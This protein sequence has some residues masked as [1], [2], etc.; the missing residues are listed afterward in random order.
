[1]PVAAWFSS[2]DTCALAASSACFSGP[3]VT[4]SWSVRACVTLVEFTSRTMS[5]WNTCSTSG[6]AT[7]MPISAAMITRA[8]PGPSRRKMFF[9]E[10]IVEVRKRSRLKMMRPHTIA[11]GTASHRL[12]RT[13]VS[14][15]NII[16]SD[17]T[18]AVPA[19]TRNICTKRGTS[20]GTSS[21]TSLSAPPSTAIRRTATDAVVED[22]DGAGGAGAARMPRPRMPRARAPRRGSPR[23]RR[24]AGALGAVDHHGVVV[25]GG[26]VV[27][28]GLDRLG[29][30]R[31][32]DERVDGLVVCGRRAP[33]LGRVVL[34][35]GG[36][37][38]RVLRGEDVVE[39]LLAFLVRREL[40]AAIGAE[41]A[42]R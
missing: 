20:S 10:R 38:G 34:G 32:D 35:L 1:M 24:R 27:A 39:I 11:R 8:W 13:P 28:G 12:T 36:A 40:D 19:S 41:A 42:G 5:F 14:S 22:R 3:L 29:V 17:E 23:S 31:V 18:R 7:T 2:A 16:D 25:V 6:S 15:A 37:V 33:R 4:A 9:V 26:G 30:A 21:R